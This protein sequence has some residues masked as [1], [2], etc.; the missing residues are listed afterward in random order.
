MKGL[1]NAKTTGPGPAGGLSFSAVVL[2]APGTCMSLL[3]PELAH[4][5]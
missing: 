5:L 3:S 2:W 4:H 1:N